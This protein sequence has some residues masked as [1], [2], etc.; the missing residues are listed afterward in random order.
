[1]IRDV[2]RLVSPGNEFSVKPLEMGIV[3]IAVF[4]DTVETINEY[5]LKKCLSKVF[6]TYRGL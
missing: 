3:G 4:N 6:C 2:N 5:Y 1:M